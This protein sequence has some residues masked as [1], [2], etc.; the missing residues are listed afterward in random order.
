MDRFKNYLQQK[1]IFFKLLASSVYIKD[2][3]GRL[4]DTSWTAE[5]R[6]GLVLVYSSILVLLL[7]IFHYIYLYI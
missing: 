5:P 4:T 7:V 1:K 2:T 3:Q 6:A